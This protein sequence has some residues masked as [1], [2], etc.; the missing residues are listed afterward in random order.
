[1]ELVLE[2]ALGLLVSDGKAADVEE[3]LRESSANSGVL[4]FQDR[5][6]NPRLLGF[7]E[8]CSSN[9]LS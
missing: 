5:L 4:F 7:V 1:M 6:Y 2:L 8:Y 3:L 9:E